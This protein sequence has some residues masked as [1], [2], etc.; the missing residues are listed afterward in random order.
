MET[1]IGIYIEWWRTYAGIVTSFNE[2]DGVRPRLAY[3][4]ITNSVDVP[5]TT[6]RPDADEPV[7]GTNRS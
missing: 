7:D 4:P 2:G 3:F 6:S 1:V 5:G